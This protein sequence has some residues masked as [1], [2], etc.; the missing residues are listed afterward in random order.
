MRLWF[1]KLL[2]HVMGAAAPEVGALFDGKLVVADIALHMRTFLNEDAACPDGALY[3]AAN[4]DL[5][6]RDVADDSSCL[7]NRKV[8]AA[9]VAINLPVDLDLAIGPKAAED[10]DVSVN[11]S[12]WRQPLGPLLC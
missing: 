8:F 1:L 9:N 5:L 11:D 12:S 10:L 6:G 2:G 3:F 4:D 7:A